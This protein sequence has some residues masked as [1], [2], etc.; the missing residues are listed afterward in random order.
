MTTCS[1]QPR[2]IDRHFD[3]SISTRDERRMREH[4]PECAPCKKYY[5]RHLLLARLDPEALAP[6]A[7][8]GRGLGIGRQRFG[9]VIPFGAVGVLAAAAA[10]LL[11]MHH[12]HDENAGFT[13]RGNVAGTTN[14][15]AQVLVYDVKPNA[16]PSLAGEVIA[17]DDE[18]AF[19]YENGAAKSRLMVFG[20]DEHRHVYW[21]FPAWTNA[22]E[23]PVAIPIEPGA[24]RR[25]L[26]FA[27]THKL[28]GQHL[29]IHSL[30]LDG[31]TSVRDVESLLQSQ[32]GAKLPISGAIETTT[33]FNI[34]P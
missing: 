23:N 9:A 28:D 22:S 3:G 6:A 4:L 24:Q 12:P 14:S 21:F 13:A 33:S 8:L 17:R 1:F 20:V 19:A 10:I 18:L 2:L 30:F 11:F 25:E 7:R 29:E 16:P 26:P 34:A 32:S 5:E 27:V 15:P 31:P